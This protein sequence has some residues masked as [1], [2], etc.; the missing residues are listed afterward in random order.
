MAQSETGCRFSDLE[1]VFGEQKLSFGEFCRLAMERGVE[2]GDVGD[3]RREMES[4]IF[5]V[6]VDH[7]L[8][9]EMEKAGVKNK[10]LVER[11]IDRGAIT[12]DNGE[13]CGIGEQI[14]SLKQSDPYLFESR[15]PTYRVKTGLSHTRERVDPEGMTDTDY[16]KNVKG[17]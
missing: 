16:Y 3:M 4:E 11:L 9:R 13:I 6:K 5:S 12:L 2:I 1:G 15:Q 8:E 14:E 10:A 7:R 17:I